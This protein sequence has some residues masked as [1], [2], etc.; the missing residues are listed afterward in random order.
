MVAKE[1]KLFAE[2]A[3]EGAEVM[4]RRA[5]GAIES[6]GGFSPNIAVSIAILGTRYHLPLIYALT[7][8]AVENLEDLKAPL[9][10]AASLIGPSP[11]DEPWLPYLGTALDAGIS[12]AISAEV[13]CALAFEEREPPYTG[14]P[15]DE[16]VEERL[17]CSIGSEDVSFVIAIGD[18]GE[19]SEAVLAEFAAKNILIIASG[20]SLASRALFKGEKSES[21]GEA[22]LPPAQI[23]AFTE[24]PAGH[25]F[26]FGALARVA[27]MEGVKP[28]D[29]R[30]VLDF[31]RRNLFGFV[32]LFDEADPISW[33]FASAGI[34]FGLAT[35]AKEYTPQLLPIY[36]VP[37]F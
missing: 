11:K 33:A 18:P 30:A 8:H 15:S 28:G 25:A 24:D 23:A 9:D 26:A 22:G 3:R 36:S 1:V 17:R 16:W 35:I 14:F 21:E 12:A 19:R 6:V 5:R 29:H 7:G 31:C 27:L 2:L 20:S 34:S 32:A 10:L 37:R 4:L 13:V